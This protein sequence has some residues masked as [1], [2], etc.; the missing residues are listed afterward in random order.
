[1]Q[2]GDGVEVDEEGGYTQCSEAETQAR[3]KQTDEEWEKVGGWEKVKKEEKTEEEEKTI[4]M[5][6]LQMGPESPLAC[7]SHKG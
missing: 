6:S 2:V 5:P 7:S 4:S 1:M 3:K